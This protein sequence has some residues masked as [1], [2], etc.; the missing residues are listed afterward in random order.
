MIVHLISKKLM[1]S[2]DGRFG[3]IIVSYQSQRYNSVHGSGRTNP[4]NTSYNKGPPYMRTARERGEKGNIHAD[5]TYATKG[6][7]NDRHE[8][9]ST[10][11]SVQILSRRK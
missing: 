11:Y 1:Y 7:Q 5:R 6:E 3:R 8:S 4:R 2:R 9:Q 10:L